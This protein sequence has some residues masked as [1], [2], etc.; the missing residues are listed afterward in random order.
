MLGAGIVAFCPDMAMVSDT[1]AL[2]GKTKGKGMGMIR[3]VTQH[4]MRLLAACALVLAAT[5]VVA[6]TATQAHATETVSADKSS[7]TILP[8]AVS[9]DYQVGVDY[10]EA[11]AAYASDST[12]KVRDF[13][14]VE[15]NKVMVK[16]LASGYYYNIRVHYKYNL[17]A[18]GTVLNGIWTAYGKT[19]APKPTSVKIYDILYNTKKLSISFKTKACDGYTVKLDPA[20]SGMSNKY[21]RNDY[22]CNEYKTI[23]TAYISASLNTAYYVSVRTYA[24]DD[25]G[26]KHY[27]DWSTKVKVIP[28]PVLTN[29]KAVKGGIRIYWNKIS[30]A[31]SYTLYTSTSSSKSSFS[32]VGT[33]KSNYKTLKT[34]KGKRVTTGKTYYGMVR[35]N[36][37]YNGKSFYSPKNWYRSFYLYRYYR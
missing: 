37:S 2:F 24:E 17:S 22:G 3:T 34:I 21:I 35:A 25:A 28:Q 31:S 30:G 18:G 5:A 16:G 9:G 29:A 26:I 14:I 6:G 23:S 1:L 19:V 15:G 12:Y 13:E 4:A 33:Y 27:S 10:V 36:G 7:I 11:A 32:K 20:K 8:S